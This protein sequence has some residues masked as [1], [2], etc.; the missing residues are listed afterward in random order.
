VSLII[1]PS[2]L[3]A[4]ACNLEQ[5]IRV[6]EKSSITSIHIDVMDGNFVPNIAFGIDQIKAL[7]KITD[8]ELDVHLMVNDPDKYIERI[9]EAGA[10]C[11]TVHEEACGHLYKT[12]TFIKS[13]GIK[14]GVA[15]NPATNIDN[16][17]YVYK[18]LNKVLIMTVEPGFGG[19]K[20]IPLMKQKIN[21]A[22]QIK[23]LGK[24]DF[25]IQVDGGIDSQNIKEVVD[26]GATDIV[27]GSSVFENRTIE[28]NIKKFYDLLGL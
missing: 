10:S 25:Q 26:L 11:I 14:A 28:N 27:I 9:I 13:F 16:L 3:S 5:D 23:T 19:Q 8:M 21:D 4:D 24:Y 22:R 2:I 7:R 20:F 15:L 1:A 12:I 17:K 6:L 18:L